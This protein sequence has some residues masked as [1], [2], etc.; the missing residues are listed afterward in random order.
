M[1]LS[2]ASDYWTD[3]FSEERS[4]VSVFIPDG[5]WYP[6]FGDNYEVCSID[7]KPGLVGGIRC[8]GRYCDNISLECIQPYKNKAGQWYPVT[9]VNNCQ[10]S[11]WYSEEQ[12]SVD[13][14]YQRYITGVECN[15]SYCDNKR[16]YVCSLV[17][18][19]P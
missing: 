8:K 9:K 3:Y 13:F 5:Y 14:G 10:W 11:G 2:S 1:T 18:P 17:D 4:N 15:G 12:G 19:A 16:F 7:G 6:Y